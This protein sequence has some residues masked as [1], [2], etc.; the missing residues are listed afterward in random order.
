MRVQTGDGVE[1]AFA[2]ITKDMLQ[3]LRPADSGGG[4]A[5]D[6]DFV[7]LN[8]EAAAGGINIKAKKIRT[9]RTCCKS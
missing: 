7:V 3:L 4:D 1:A 9:G 8:R 6:G 2:Q 5:V